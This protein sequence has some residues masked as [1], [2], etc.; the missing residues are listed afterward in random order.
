MLKLILPAAMLIV[1]GCS[2]QTQSNI[3]VTSQAATQPNKIASYR[4]EISELAENLV[5]THPVPYKYISKKNF[6]ALV[7]KT[8]AGITE[9]TSKADLLWIYS[10]IISS[11]GCAHTLMPFFNQEDALIKPEERFPVDARFFGNRLYIIDSLTNAGKL[12]AGTEIETI[13]GRNV[14][15]LYDEIAQHIPSDGYNPHFPHGLINIS[16][17][18]YMTYALD[19]PEKYELT[20]KGKDQPV[21]LTPLHQFKH[22]PII[23]PYDPCKK[24]L[25]YREVN[26]DTAVMTIRNWDFY[27]ERGAIFKKFIDDNFAKMQTS[28]IQS[29]IVDVRGNLGGTNFATAYLL[30]HIAKKPFRFGT[31][32]SA[33]AKELKEMLPPI[34]TGFKGKVY[35]LSNG[36]TQSATTHFLALAKY[37]K[38]GTIVGSPSGSASTVND[39]KKEFISSTAGIKYYVARDTFS[40]DVNGFTE[41]DGIAPDIAVHPTIEDYLQGRDPALDHAIKISAK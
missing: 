37:H 19:F 36:Q 7:A 27:G 11:I 2:H 5:S 17:S 1:A 29:L 21:L 12:S 23:P 26:G 32:D 9:D 16:F 34:L 31:M 18:S 24:T 35:I 40:V 22:K 28:N 20:A 33:G 14:Q 41:S 30:R 6:D 3:I 13:N 39:N 4:A 15:D 10:R 38:M 25:C 8:K